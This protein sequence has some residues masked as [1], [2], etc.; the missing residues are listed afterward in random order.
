MGCLIIRHGL[1]RHAYH[2]VD[3]PRL[4][5]SH[6]VTASAQS[7]SGDTILIPLTGPATTWTADGAPWQNS[8]FAPGYQSLAGPGSEVPLNLPPR[9]AQIDLT[10]VQS[11]DRPVYYWPGSR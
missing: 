3:E 7:P 2:A 1:S 4:V 10:D 11:W 6:A 9:A 8:G 5:T